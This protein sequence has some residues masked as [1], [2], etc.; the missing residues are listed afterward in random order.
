MILLFPQSIP[1]AVL[2]YRQVSVSD[3]AFVADQEI[4]LLACSN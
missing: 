1:A 4:N 2:G 3:V